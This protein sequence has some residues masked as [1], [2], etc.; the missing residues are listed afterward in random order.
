MIVDSMSALHEDDGDPA[1]AMDPKVAWR[2]NR[3]ESSAAHKDGAKE[4]MPVKLAQTA[5]TALVF[6][7]EPSSHGVRAV[8]STSALPHHN[9]LL[10]GEPFSPTEAA[11][12]HLSRA[13]GVVACASGFAIVAAGV[14]LLF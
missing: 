9:A 1:F 13:V 10:F 5:H 11:I 8:A 6:R 2:V 4:I 7:Q 12:H 3:I 14:A